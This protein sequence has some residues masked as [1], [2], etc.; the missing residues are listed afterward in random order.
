MREVSYYEKTTNPIDP[1]DKDAMIKAKDKEILRL[2]AENEYLKKL[3]AA[4]QARK[5][6]Q[7]KK[8]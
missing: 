5:N 4:V 1:M 8:K 3:R 7:P 6:Q 2:K